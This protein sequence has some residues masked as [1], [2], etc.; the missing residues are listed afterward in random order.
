MKCCMCQEREA[1]H[2]CKVCTDGFCPACAEIH[3]SLFRFN[4]AFFTEADFV[5]LDKPNATDK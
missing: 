4:T 5:Q 2:F 1:D 3:K